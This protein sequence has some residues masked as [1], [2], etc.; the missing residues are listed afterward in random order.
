LYLSAD[1][2]LIDDK[3]AF[4]EVRDFCLKAIT[5]R[6]VLRLALRKGLIA[7]LQK[8]ESALRKRRF[9]LTEEN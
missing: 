2:V 3:K 6:A 5:T 9:F 8:I 4:K 7:D 1:L